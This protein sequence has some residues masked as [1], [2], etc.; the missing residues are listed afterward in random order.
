MSNT[1]PDRTRR[2]A[3]HVRT[4]GVSD[5]PFD[6]DDAVRLRAAALIERSQLGTSRAP[7]DPYRAPERLSAHVVVRHADGTALGC[8]ALAEVDDGVVEIQ[9]FYVRF[10]ARGLGAGAVLLEALEQRARALGS[11]ATVIET[12]SALPDMVN[13]LMRNG[14]QQIAP[15]GPY[16]ARIASVCFSKVL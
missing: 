1:Y 8:G 7:I 4:I 6:S 13:F 3:S 10:D 15:W 12:T 5:E 14:Y 16:L 9:R 11:G 2:P